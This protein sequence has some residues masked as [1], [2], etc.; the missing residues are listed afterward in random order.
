M[1]KLQ[2]FYSI[3]HYWIFLQYKFPLIIHIVW[4]CH[5]FLLFVK[6]GNIPWFAGGCVEGRLMHISALLNLLRLQGKFIKFKLEFH[7][8]KVAMFSRRERQ[9]MR[10]K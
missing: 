1:L 8:V 6:K 4:S 3:N 2:F 9:G 5:I 7:V 10:L